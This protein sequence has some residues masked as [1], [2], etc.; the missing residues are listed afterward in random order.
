[1]RGSRIK[2]YLLLTRPHN[3]AALV[4][5]TLIGWLT[6]ATAF[7][8]NQLINPLYP[9]GTVLL[10]AAGGYVINDYF[11]YEV[12]LINKPYRPIPSGAVSRGEA[13]SLSIFLGVSGVIIATPSGPVTTLFAAG[14]GLLIYLYSYKLKELGFIGNLVVA[15]E[16]AS[17]IIYG[18]VAALEFS[19]GLSLTYVP[20]IPSIYAFLLLLGR[21]VVKTIE[22]YRADEVRE[23]KSIPR[24]FGVKAASYLSASLLAGVTALSPIPY[25]KGY[26]L[27]YLSLALL[28]DALLIHSV[29]K[30]VRIPLSKGFE[31]VAGKLRSVLKVAIFTGSMAFFLD[32][33]LQVVSSYLT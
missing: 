33:L 24:L 26:G 13:L 31:V 21:E 17:S 6:V 10:V 3:L 32:L 16:G 25:F 7:P 2:G 30:L 9:I 11:D 12:D 27:M 8:T 1:M 4:V 22:D 20:L 28:T 15:Y 23:V 14:N 19:G 5:T 29:I 18:A